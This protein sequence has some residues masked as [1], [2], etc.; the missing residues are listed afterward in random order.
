MPTISE[1]LDTQIKDTEAEIARL[2][3]AYAE[4]TAAAEARLALLQRAR[5]AVTRE[6]DRLVGELQAAGVWPRG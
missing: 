6:L 3:T 2:A 4:N 5:S 1:Q